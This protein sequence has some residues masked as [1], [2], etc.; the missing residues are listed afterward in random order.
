MGVIHRLKDQQ[1]SWLWD[2]VDVKTYN[3][4]NATKQVLIGHDDGAHN[5]EVRYFTIPP[6]GFSSYD[7]HAHDHGVVVMH[8]KAEV[9]LGEEKHEVNAGDVIYIPSNETHQF[10]NLTDEPF[11]F[12]CIIPPKPLDV[13]EREKT[14]AQQP[15]GK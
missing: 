6:R 10:E 8:G 11:T 2:G 15:L 5:F 13:H 3:A 12:L 14:A 9:L 4:N 1:S 7:N